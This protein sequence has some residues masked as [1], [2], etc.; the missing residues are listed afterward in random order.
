MCNF[1]LIPGLYMYTLELSFLSQT[2]SHLHFIWQILDAT[3]DTLMPLAIARMPRS[4]RK[5]QE[6]HIFKDFSEIIFQLKQ[7]DY[8]IFAL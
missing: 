6:E 4:W 5:Y 3:F 1:N 7:I 2:K 8:G